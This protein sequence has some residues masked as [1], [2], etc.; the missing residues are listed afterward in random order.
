[1]VPPRAASRFVLPPAG[2]FKL[3]KCQAIFCYNPGA[4]Q[5]GKP[6][7][8]DGNETGTATCAIDAIPVF[9][10]AFGGASG[11]ERAHDDDRKAPGAGMAGKQLVG[12]HDLI[13][14]EAAFEHVQQALREAGLHDHRFLR[15]SWTEFQQG[16]P[17]TDDI[18]AAQQDRKS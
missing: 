18:R 5:A 1:M 15:L 8:A 13:P 4:V 2:I 11:I 16:R 6:M 12:A 3:W 10:L 14:N 17:V 9:F 7:T